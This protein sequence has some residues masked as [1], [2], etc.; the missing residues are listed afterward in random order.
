[1]DT[2][3]GQRV[4]NGPPPEFFASAALPKYVPSFSACNE[5]LGGRQAGSQETRALPVL[6]VPRAWDSSSSHH[7][8]GERRQECGRE[9]SPALS[10]LSCLLRT[11]PGPE[12][13]NPP[14]ARCVVRALRE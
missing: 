3:A 13:G 14:N 1:M 7:S 6:Q 2:A 8:E 9:R 12:E 11:Q 4:V 10:Q 5:L